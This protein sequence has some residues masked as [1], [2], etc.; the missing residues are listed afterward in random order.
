[1]SPGA[2][3]WH[4]DSGKY[5][6]EIQHSKYNIANRNSPKV[7]LMQLTSK[8]V[9]FFPMRGDGLLL[10][11]PSVRALGRGRSLRRPFI[12]RRR[13]QRQFSSPR[14]PHGTDGLGDG[15]AR[16]YTVS[17][18]LGMVG[19]FVKRLLQGKVSPPGKCECI[20]LQ[21]SQV[22]PIFATN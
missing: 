22:S 2:Q 10:P 16:Q 9:F 3:G 4:Y 13:I 20:L 11:S 12:L 19:L 14:A 1:M 7:D 18:I 6:I 8:D 21:S 5:Y 17:R 15:R